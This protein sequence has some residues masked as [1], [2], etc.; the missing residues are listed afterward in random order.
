MLLTQVEIDEL[1]TLG[2]FGY[3]GVRGVDWLGVPLRSEGRT[4]GAMVVQSYEGD[5]P[6]PS[7]T[8]TS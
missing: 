1:V 7:R 5:P 4:V 8:K 2:E 3:V 6:T